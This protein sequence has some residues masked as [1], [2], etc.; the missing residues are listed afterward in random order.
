MMVIF[1]IIMLFIFRYKRGFDWLKL[2]KNRIKSML[3]HFQFQD[4]RVQFQDV[5]VQ[6]QDVRVQF[7]D[8]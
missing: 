6:S 2:V 8:V 7:Q 3:G 4:V 5:H 1:L